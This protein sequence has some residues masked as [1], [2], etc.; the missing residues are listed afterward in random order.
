MIVI[1]I[2]YGVSVSTDDGTTWHKV[3]N[4][5]F[6]TKLHIDKAENTRSARRRRSVP[7]YA[8]MISKL[9]L[10][11]ENEYYTGQLASGKVNVIINGTGTVD[12]PF[13]LELSFPKSGVFGPNDPEEK[14]RLRASDFNQSLGTTVT[15]D[16]N[17]YYV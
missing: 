17:N 7:I 12:E 9:T 10:D 4:A 5:E 15:E 8:G 11:L 3:D 2:T 16:A 14:Y 1:Q 6:V 13:L